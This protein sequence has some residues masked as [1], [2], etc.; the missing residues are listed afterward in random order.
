MSLT[1]TTTP[2][3]DEIGERVEQLLDRIAELEPRAAEAADDLVRALVQ[4]YGAGLQTVVA[5]LEGRAPEVLAELADDPLVAGLL[6]LHDLQPRALRDRVEAALDGIRPM[7]EGHGGDVTL[8]GVA[9]DVVHL[10][11]EGTCN[12]CGASQSTLENAVEA[13][14]RAAAPE[15]DRLEV[16][17]VVPPPDATDGLIPLESLLQCPSELEQLPR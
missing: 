11:L 15:V 12:G 3:L 17:G 4:L 8:L 1:E 7:L 14:V 10:R 2:D 13:A 5:A 6:S 16:E 9:D